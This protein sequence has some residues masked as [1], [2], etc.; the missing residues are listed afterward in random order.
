ML[1]RK[2]FKTMNRIQWKF[3]V[4][5]VATKLKTFQDDL[6]L[7]FPSSRNH[8]IYIEKVCECFNQNYNNRLKKCYGSVEVIKQ[9][10]FLV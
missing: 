10:I 2:K 3:L 7:E 1:F 6:D 8:E 4:S 9:L 5:I